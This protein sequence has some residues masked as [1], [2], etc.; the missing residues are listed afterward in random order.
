MV[1][2]LPSQGSDGDEVKG[3]QDQLELQVCYGFFLIVA[4][5]PSPTLSTDRR[6]LLSPLNNEVPTWFLASGTAVGRC[7]G[8]QEVQACTPGPQTTEPIGGL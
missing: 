2:R 5:S 1:P 8:R 4:P 7:H 6:S 3:I